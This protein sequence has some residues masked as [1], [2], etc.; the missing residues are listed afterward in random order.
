MELEAGLIVDTAPP[1][2]SL[3]LFLKGFGIA[4]DMLLYKCVTSSAGMIW[5]WESRTQWGSP[6]Q[7]S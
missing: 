6:K 7:A 3:C 5:Q 2:T 1:E 4:I